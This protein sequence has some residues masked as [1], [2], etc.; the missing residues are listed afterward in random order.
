MSGLYGDKLM[1]GVWLLI[2]LLIAPCCYAFVY[3][4]FQLLGFS[5][6]YLMGIVIGIIIYGLYMV[7]CEN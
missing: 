5:I 2:T 1:L 7:E 4:D 3:H 6:G